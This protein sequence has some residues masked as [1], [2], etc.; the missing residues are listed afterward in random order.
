[1]VIVPAESDD[2]ADDRWNVVLTH[3]RIHLRAH[4][5]AMVALRAARG[6]VRIG[7]IRLPGLLLPASA[8]NRNAPVTMP[9]LLPVS[10]NPTMRTTWSGRARSA[11]KFLEAPGMARRADFEDR[12]R[13]AAR[14]GSPTVGV[15]PP[16]AGCSS[17]PRSR[18]AS[19]RWQRYGGKIQSRCLRFRLGCRSEQGGAPA[20]DYHAQVS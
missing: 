4:G 2:W 1:M 13:R 14:S 18:F 15:R 10:C 6:G 19:S 5:P 11:S 8:G 16:R 7:F 17:W 20:N 3:E 12:V 9:C